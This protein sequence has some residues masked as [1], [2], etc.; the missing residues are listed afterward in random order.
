VR[1][2]K[3]SAGEF[4][5]DVFDLFV[6]PDFDPETKLHDL[7]I[8]Q[9]YPLADQT[10]ESNVIA[11]A[12]LPT[13]HDVDMATC[14]TAGWGE[15][16]A[17]D[18]PPA[19]LNT[20][21]ETA[22]N[23]FPHDYC[24][25]KTDNVLFK[26]D[27]FCAGVPDQND[28]GMADSGNGLCHFDEG[29][30]LIC[31]VNGQPVLYGVTSQVSCGKRNDATIFAKT[32]GSW[33]SPWIAEIIGQ[34]CPASDGKC[35][36]PASTGV[37][38]KWAGGKQSKILYKTDDAVMTRITLPQYIFDFNI[39]ETPYLIFAI[40]QRRYCGQGFFDAFNAEEMLYKEVMDSDDNYELQYT[41]TKIDDRYSSLTMQIRMHTVRDEDLPFWKGAKVVKKDQ[42]FLLLGGLE[43]VDW[44]DKDRQL[45]FEK[46]VIG[47]MAMP[48]D[49]GDPQ[50]NFDY[51]PCV[52]EEKLVGF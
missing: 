30:P 6:H 40:F 18:S 17:A 35:L 43:N 16:K 9:F 25:A 21:R 4:T 42:L 29:N 31:P 15:N 51:T 3:F 36:Y 45:C 28:D 49:V 8:M 48:S 50:G 10:A 22:L 33:N 44:R 14:W 52:S 39:R 5:A 12:C 13:N 1:D 23:V 34:E 26:Y 7:C 47:G 38:V 19:P 27:Q 20:A 32:A 11:P 46:M 2:N 24:L 37:P 41:T